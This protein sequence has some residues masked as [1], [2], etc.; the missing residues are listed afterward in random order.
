[1]LHWFAHTLEPLQAVCNDWCLH[2]WE[3]VGAWFTGLATFGAV[4]VSLALARREGIRFKVS[5]SCLRVWEPPY[6]EVLVITV[7]NV[8]SRPVTIEGV[9]WR[10]RPWG[11]LHGYQTFNAPGFPGPPAVIAEGNS[12]R[13]SLPLSTGDVQWAEPFLRDFVGGWPRIAVHLVRVR[14]WTP[15]GNTATAFLD[16]SLKKWLVRRATSP[17]EPNNADQGDPPAPG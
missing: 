8:G 17:P 12:H 13:F 11:R 3:A 1:M 16:P 4:L 2:W 14:A 15:A 6:P 10:R 5:A 9:G 7:R